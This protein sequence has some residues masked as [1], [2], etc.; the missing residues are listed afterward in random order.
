[1]PNEPAKRWAGLILGLAAALA[2][3][4]GPPPTIAPR[5]TLRGHAKDVDA[6]AFRPDGRALASRG[7]D[8][9]RVWD[10]ASAKEVA[11]FPQDGAEFGGLA[12]SP[13]GRSL[14]A[15]DKDGAEVRDLAAG[16]VAQPTRLARPKR[17]EV[18]SGDSASYG[19]GLAYSPD[20]KTLAGGGSNQGSDGYTTL[21][22]LA[23]GS[24]VDIGQHAGPACSVAF[25]PDGQF[26][27]SKSIGGRLELWDAASRTL[28]DVIQAGQSFQAPACFSPDGRRI[29]SVGADR[30]VQLWDVKT[31]DPSTSLKGHLKAVLGLAFHPGGLILASSDAGGT[32]FLWDIAARKPVAQCQGHQGKAWSV[33]FSPDGRTLASGGEDRTVRLWDV[34]EAAALAVPK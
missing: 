1:M 9:V 15:N 22:D 7:G 34:A 23:S 3:C 21:W 14:A 2:G 20:G 33:A 8:S 29:A 13:D 31:G 25:S 19:W 5:A 24:G 4:D 12:Y 28:A 18:F 16:P 30:R 32:I 27:A 17:T 10:V 6:V 11:S 26:L